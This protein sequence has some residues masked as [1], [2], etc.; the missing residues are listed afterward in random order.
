MITSYQAKIG[1]SRLMMHNEQLAN[2]FNEF[3]QELSKLTHKR[4]KTLEDF[5]AIS[6][7]EFMGGLYFE[8]KAGPYIP[9]HCLHKC[10]IMGARRRKLGKQCEQMVLIESQVNPVQYEGPRTRKSLWEAM[11]GSE[12]RFVDSRLV[13]V[14]SNRT[15]RTRPLFRDW[16]C[17]FVINV[18]DGAVNAE[19]IR[20][21]LEASETIGILDG[22]PMYAGQFRV[23]EFGA[24]REAYDV[25]AE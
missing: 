14:N 24:R 12:R 6:K 10:L 13:G 1:G 5:L 3:T 18:L 17:E 7:V 15:M 21:A 19:D 22:R 20:T 11:S 2:P 4:G 23:L 25:A 9:G 8:D 16:S